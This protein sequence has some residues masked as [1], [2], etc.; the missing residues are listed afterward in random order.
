MAEAV[1][2]HLTS[3]SSLTTSTN[4]NLS[5]IDS[6]GTGAYHVSSAP[7]P[8]TTS[9][10]IDHG[11]TTYRHAARKIRP[12]DFRDFDYIL[13]MDRENLADVEALRRRMKVTGEGEAYERARVRLFGD[14]GGTVGEE[15]GDPYY[16]A[17]DGFEV[18]YEQMVRFSRGLIESIA[19]G[20]TS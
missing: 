10:L 15:V 5:T 20:G 2:R 1:F 19:Q 17:R 8:R 6:C 9:T 18:A 11:I 12:E 7:D 3:P 13:V 4:L 16:G 14:F